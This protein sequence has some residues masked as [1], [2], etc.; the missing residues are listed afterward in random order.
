[1][2]DPLP[3]SMLGHSNGLI[4]RRLRLLAFLRREAWQTGP[5]AENLKK[6]KEGTSSYNLE[7]EVIKSNRL[8][9]RHLNIDLRSHKI[10]NQK[11]WKHAIY[12]QLTLNSV[13]FS[14]VSQKERKIQLKP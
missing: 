8:P 1:M 9:T 13:A 6:N 10:E 2:F 7:V 14:A 5:G 11:K 3:A 12:E 4:I